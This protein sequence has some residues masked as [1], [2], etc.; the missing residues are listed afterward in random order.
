MYT[1]LLIDG[2]IFVILAIVTVYTIVKLHT[3]SIQ[4]RDMIR[5]ELKE[6][7]DPTYM[8]TMRSDMDDDSMVKGNDDE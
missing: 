4:L 6:D 5:E 7:Y 3:W 8:K 1:E 2:I